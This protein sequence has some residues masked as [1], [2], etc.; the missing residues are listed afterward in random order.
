MSYYQ[1]PVTVQVKRADAKFWGTGNQLGFVYEVSPRGN[2]FPVKTTN[3]DTI[4]FKKTEASFGEQSEVFFYQIPKQFDEFVPEGL[5][6]VYPPIWGGIKGYLVNGGLNLGGIPLLIY[7]VM[8]PLRPDD[9][10]NFLQIKLH[11]IG[12]ELV[13]T[14]AGNGIGWFLKSPTNITLAYSKHPHSVNRAEWG[15][16]V[17]SLFV[18]YKVIFSRGGKW[19]WFRLGIND[20]VEEFC[21]PSPTISAFLSGD[22]T[23][24]GYGAFRF[25]KALY[26]VAPFTLFN[27]TYPANLAPHQILWVEDRAGDLIYHEDNYFPE[28]SSNKVGV[29]LRRCIIYHKP[30]INHLGIFT[31]VTAGIEDLSWSID[32]G[33]L[34]VK[35]DT[36]IGMGDALK[37]IIGN[38][39]FLYRVKSVE[40]EHS[41]DEIN[42]TRKTIELENPL[43]ANYHT[44]PIEFNPYLLRVS[45]IIKAMGCC[46]HLNFNIVHGSV[47]NDSDIALLND[48]FSLN[49]PQ[50]WAEMLLK[51]AGKEDGARWWVWGNTIY[52][53]TPSQAITFNPPPTSQV[54]SYRI[55]VDTS[56]PTIGVV[57][58]KIIV[59]PDANN[60]GV[61]IRTGGYPIRYR[62][63]WK[64][65]GL[66]VLPEGG[67][68]AYS[69]KKAEVTKVSWSITAP[70]EAETEVELE[71]IWA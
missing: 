28:R 46:V 37:I 51:I 21:V 1:N 66:F 27:L 32:G 49:S 25:F 35:G 13:V 14:P 61:S 63:F 36:T 57:G 23:L 54:I 47:L 62:E 7:T 65:K 53:Q 67:Y 3:G 18:D 29:V 39:E 4:Y 9:K 43:L 33:R 44:V 60:R 17:F 71:V 69:N 10:I 20:S 16:Y 64:V 55:V 11:D 31:D 5:R 45:D 38:T 50:D 19:L 52:L 26:D 59:S 6:E 30:T 56:M 41:G 22:V 40:V 42:I 15:S 8:P 34:T 2:Y 58:N 48:R 12:C 24:I 68:V 70:H